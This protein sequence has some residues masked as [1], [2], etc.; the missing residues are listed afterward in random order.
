MFIYNI[1]HHLR[2][3]ISYSLLKQCFFIPIIFSRN[4]S[5][6]QHLL[7]S[8]TFFSLFTNYHFL[9]P[10][11]V[12]WHLL[13]LYWLVFHGLLSL[14]SKQNKT[15]QLCTTWAGVARP[16]WAVHPLAL[17]TNQDYALQTC[18]QASLIEAFSQSRF[19]LFRWSSLVSSW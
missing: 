2:K 11:S 8:F 12:V 5:Y 19:P 9:Y 14:S 7:C 17:H 13:S 18:L 1:I 10:I 3:V 4:S 15:K 16:Q 6:T